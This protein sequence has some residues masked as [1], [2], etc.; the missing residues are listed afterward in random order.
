MAR[1]EKC[2][3]D[4]CGLCG[5][6]RCAS[7]SAACSSGSP[8]PTGPT[9]TSAASGTGTGPAELE[10]DR[11]PAGARGHGRQSSGARDPRVGHSFM[12]L[13]RP[14]HTAIPREL[15]AVVTAPTSRATADRTASK[16]RGPGGNLPSA[17]RRSFTTPRAGARPRSNGEQRD[18]GKYVAMA[19]ALA[20]SRGYKLDRHARS[21]LDQSARPRQGGV[22]GSLPGLPRLSGILDSVAGA[23]IVDIQAQSDERVASQYAGF[24]KAGAEAIH[25]HNP[26]AVS[27]VRPVD[28]PRRSAPSPRRS[29]RRRHGGDGQGRR[30]ILD[31]HPERPQPVLPEGAVRPS[32]R[33]RSA[34]LTI[35]FSGT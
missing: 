31:Q 9:G 14:G 6:R 4:S 8:G 10:L 2:T 32:P 18:V 25:Q 23:D 3:T 19:T 29:P 5:R 35:A 33:W 26:S 16:R 15:N 13:S 7:S 27:R 24:V 17:P 20:H 12:R 30:R 34:R 11:H 28:Q 1:L 21:R 22:R